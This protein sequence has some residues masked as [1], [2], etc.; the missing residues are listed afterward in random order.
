MKV[1]FDGQIFIEQTNGGISR[2]FANLATG[3]DAEPGVTARIVAPFHRNYHLLDHREAPVLG[4]GLP[5]KWR[6]G[7]ICWAGIKTFSPMISGLGHP[8]IAHETYFSPRPYLTTARRRVTTMYDMI[9]EIYH[10]GCETSQYKRATLARCDHVVCISHNTKNDLCEML[11]FPPER[12]SVTHLGYQDFGGFAGHAVPAVLAEKPYFL[13]VGHR[14]GYKNFGALVRAFASAP[15]LV[16]EARL[17]CFGGGGFTTEESAFAA[18]LGLSAQH[19]AHLGGEDE[20]LGVAYANALAFVCPSLYEGFGLPPLE[21]MSAGCPV[22]SSNRSSLPEVVGE[23]ALLF[24]P[25]DVEALRD[26]MQRVFDS[27]ELRRQLV[28]R[29][30]EQRRHFSWS[31]CA[32]DTLAVYQ[33]IL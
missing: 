21:A 5:P 32:A 25:E 11:D 1:Y 28:A 7:R 24:D 20:A 27:A 6:V 16:R 18:G 2:Y 22:L 13:Y 10:P 26:A 33:S 9:H 15:Q 14:V 19:L 17:V 12:A 3:L 4:F 29:G 8:D 23:A 31:R 30:H